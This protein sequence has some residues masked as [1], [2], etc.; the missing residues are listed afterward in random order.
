MESERYRYLFDKAPE[1]NAEVEDWVE[2]FREFDSFEEIYN[3]GYLDVYAKMCVVLQALVHPI[4]DILEAKICQPKDQYYRMA[5]LDKLI[6]IFGH[7]P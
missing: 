1:L 3:S 7:T 6:R 4:E 5:E 2:Y